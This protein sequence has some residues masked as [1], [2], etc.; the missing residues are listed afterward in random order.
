[1]NL[2]MIFVCIF[3]KQAKLTRRSAANFVRTQFNRKYPMHCSYYSLYLIAS[4]VV[5]LNRLLGGDCAR[6]ISDS[7]SD[8]CK[9]GKVTKGIAFDYLRYMLV[10]KL[11]G[12]ITSIDDNNL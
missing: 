11:N 4:I 10:L 5:S 12:F 7:W 2:L 1:M 8:F 9:S 6:E 3:R